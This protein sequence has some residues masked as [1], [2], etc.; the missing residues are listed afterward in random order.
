[1]SD[2]SLVYGNKERIFVNTVL[3]CR[4]ECSYCYLPEFDLGEKI[5]YFS[6]KDVIEQVIGLPYFVKGKEGTIIS[7][8]CYSECWDERNRKETMYLIK[9]FAQ[10]GNYMQLATK[11]EIL[12]VDL[13]TIDK[14]LLFEKQLG[15]YI[16]V[17]CISA[18]K[19][20]EP[21]TDSVKKRLKPLEYKNQ[22]YG[23][24]FVLYIK[25]VLQNVT[26]KD[27]QEFCEL[28]KKFKIDTVI[29]PL[30]QLN[31][32]ILADKALVGENRLKEIDCIDNKFLIEELKSVG[33]VFIHSTDI[34]N[35]LRTEG[36]K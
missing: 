20:L 25:P 8:G 26:I 17:P 33:K 10:F 3:G 4:A 36:G 31:E 12:L 11:K 22:F 14:M 24:Y 34:I 7:I 21:G 15:I 19:Q 5:Q 27:K 35:D 32:E 29:G 2:N 30:L 16:S 18:S 28:V 6:A 13:E 1:M 9:V 23:I